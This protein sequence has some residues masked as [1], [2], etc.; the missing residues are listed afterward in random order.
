[1]EGARAGPV[2]FALGGLFV[3]VFPWLIA[4]GDRGRGYLWFTRVLTVLVAL[5]AWQVANVALRPRV[6]SVPLPGGWEIPMSVGAWGFFL[7]T[8]ATLSVLAWAAWGR[9]YTRP[10]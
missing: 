1:M 9:R 7:I 2:W 8:V 3:V 4:R 10:S 5:R 6:P